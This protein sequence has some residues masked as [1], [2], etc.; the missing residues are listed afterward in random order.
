MCSFKCKWDILDEV[1]IWVLKS[2][3]KARETSFIK[4]YKYF[5]LNNNNKLKINI[6]W[7][8][9]NQTKHF[10][11]W[12]EWESRAT[13]LTIVLWVSMRWTPLKPEL[14]CS[15]P[16]TLAFRKCFQVSPKRQTWWTKPKLVSTTPNNSWAKPCR[17]T[18][19]WKTSEAAT[20]ASNQQLLFRPTASTTTLRLNATAQ[21][22]P[23]IA[24]LGRRTLETD[25]KLKYSA[26]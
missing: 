6:G 14:C 24:A 13:P 11:W 25:N 15:P 22:L 23:Q 7:T 2:T 5:S 12:T 26:S 8:P 1:E 20:E 4:L 19:S 9:K 3:Q 10:L 21:R 16:T 18:T 17:A